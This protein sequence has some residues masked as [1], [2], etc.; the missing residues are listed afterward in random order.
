MR[1]E[2]ANLLDCAEAPGLFH[3]WQ[4]FMNR[5]ILGFFVISPRQLDAVL[6]SGERYLC[7]IE[8]TRIDWIEPFR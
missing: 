6:Q 4:L 3:S 1:F 2:L 8:R 5:S 7:H